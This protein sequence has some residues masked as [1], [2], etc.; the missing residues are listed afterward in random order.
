M[1]LVIANKNYSSWSLRPW[2]LMKHFGISFEEIHIWLGQ[3]D[4]AQQIL[5][6][7][8]SGRIPCLIDENRR[9]IWDSLAIAETLAERFPQ[10]ALWPSDAASRAHARSVSA[11][12]H[13]GFG[14]LRSEMPMKIRTVLPGLSFSAEAL[15]DV[16]RIDAVWRECLSQY[17]GPFLFGE[18]SIADAMFAPV[19]MRFN[20]YSPALSPEAAAYAAHLSAQPEMQ[21]WIY[22]AQVEGHAIARYEVDADPVADAVSDVLAN[23]AASAAP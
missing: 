18:F 5:K 4:T 14:A 1:Q 10:H 22:D 12:M 11:E 17:G 20:S 13:S 19:V 15:A 16:A 6:Y 21:V 3:D 8:P 9:A 2:V 23:V 7:S